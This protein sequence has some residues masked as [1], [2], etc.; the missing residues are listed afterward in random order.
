MKGLGCPLEPCTGLLRVGLGPT[1]GHEVVRVAN[2]L[3][4]VTRFL[5]LESVEGVAVDVAQKR[6][7]RPALRHAGHAG[8]GYPVLHHS[9]SQPHPYQP[10]HTAVRYLGFIPAQ[11][12]SELNPVE[13]LW[14]NPKARELPNRC[15]STVKLL[16]AAARHSADRVRSEREL[17]FSFLRYAAHCL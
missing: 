14:A 16:A 8:D 13:G 11:R 4:E 17:L 6:R 12:S 10:E 1:Q 15:H 9:R 2:D 5:L 3:T 7:Y